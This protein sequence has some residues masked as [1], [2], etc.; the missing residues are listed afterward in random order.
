[1]LS[2]KDLTIYNSWNINYPS[3]PVRSRLFQLEPIGIGTPYVESLTSYLTRLAESHTVLLGDLVAKQIN[4]IVPKT[5]QS[6]DLFCTKHPSGTANSTGIVA[7]Y[8]LS[9]LKQLTLREDLDNLTLLKWSQVFPQ[10]KLIHPIKQWCPACYQE[11]HSQSNT[12]YE[13]LL[14]FLKPVK[15]CPLH[16]IFLECTCPHCYQKLPSLARN[17][18]VGYCNNCEQWL[19]STIN[20]ELLQTKE[21]EWNLWVATNVGEILATSSCIS[22]I[23]TKDKISKSMQI[24]IEQMT[25]GNIAAFA[26]LIKSPKNQ[27]WGWNNGKVIP[28]LN[29]LLK[30]SAF[31]GLSLLDFLTKDD[32]KTD[33][34]FDD[35]KLVNRRKTTISKQ[36]FNFSLA[37]ESLKKI[38]SN[39][40]LPPPSM[41]DVAKQLGYH[42]RTLTK[43]FPELCKQISANYLEY[44]KNSRT[45]RIKKYCLEVEQVVMTL[46]SQGVYPSEANVSKL[47]SKAGGFREQEVREALRKARQK[48]GIR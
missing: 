39:S 21:Q 41:C 18:R 6:R 34:L 23:I 22:K 31:T 48:L 13:Q 5:Y 24:C 15:I 19:G 35:T 26:R 8:L 42:R 27:V 1:M 36:K 47:L 38:L 29:I 30:I 33:Y 3:I 2:S 43:K 16:K 4:P 9:A 45:Q 25:E 12:V 28:Q 7:K 46:N 40:S 10:R 11:Q 17:S 32:F 20:N 37:E 14:W 44:Q